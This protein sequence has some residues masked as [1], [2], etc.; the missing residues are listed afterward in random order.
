M[1][2]KGEPTF[3]LYNPATEEFVADVHQAGEADI[4]AAVA[5]A[6]AAFPK[7]RDMPI[8]AKA[9]LFGKLAQLITQNKDDLWELES[10]AM[11][12]YVNIPQFWSTFNIRD[13]ATELRQM[14]LIVP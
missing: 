14:K 13:A 6:E 8:T 12:R 10:I 4:D 9:P 5:A 3:P 7:W 2:S 1:E 11:G